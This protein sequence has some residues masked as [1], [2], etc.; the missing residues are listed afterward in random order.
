MLPKQ[1]HIDVEGACTV[2]SRWCLS[3]QPVARL[4]VAL[5]QP[6]ECGVSCCAVL[7]RILLQV[8]G[9]VLYNGHSKDELVVQRTTAY[10]DQVSCAAHS[11]KKQLAS[12]QPS[13]TRVSQGR[14]WVYNPANP[15]P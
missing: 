11:C 6:C 7:C 10:V 2:S 4:L 14:V 3:L 13:A 9:D 5:R 15:S 12:Q 1:A 8:S